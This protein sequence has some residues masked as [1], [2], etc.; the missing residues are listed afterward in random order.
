MDS[1]TL[2]TLR[3]P[4]LL[5]P[6]FPNPLSFKPPRATSGAIPVEKRTIRVRKA[7]TPS[8]LGRVAGVSS[9]LRHSPGAPNTN[10]RRRARW[11]ACGSATAGDTAAG[12][13]STST[14][15]G[16]SEQNTALSGPCAPCSSTCFTWVDPRGE[17]PPTRTYMY[18]AE[19]N[20]RGVAAGGGRA[21]EPVGPR[22]TGA[23]RAAPAAHPSTQRRWCGHRRCVGTRT[24]A[25]TQP[26]RSAQRR[27]RLNDQQCRGSR[28]DGSGHL[29]STVRCVRVQQQHRRPLHRV[30]ARAEPESVALSTSRDHAR[31]RHAHPPGFA[32]IV[33]VP[34]LRALA[35]GG[36]HGRK[37]DVMTQCC[38]DRARWRGSPMW[39]ARASVT[40]THSPE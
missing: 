2:Q 6:G 12:S 25:A 5:T 4:S 39:R 9:L 13:S 23:A 29:F 32:D 27:C 22:G 30:C 1:T 34:G 8:R 11:Q 31:H 24:A 18:A 26:H 20:T 40:L 21:N 38:G 33:A 15:G 36:S 3:D 28:V 14:S 19:V 10:C 17:H 35:R 7:S 16:G 37:G